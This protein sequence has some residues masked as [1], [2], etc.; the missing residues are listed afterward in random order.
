MAVY[1]CRRTAWWTAA[2]SS[3]SSNGIWPVDSVINLALSTSFA[4]KWRKRTD[5]YPQHSVFAMITARE[6]SKQEPEKSARTLGEDVYAMNELKG[7]CLRVGSKQ[8]GRIQGKTCF[9][10]KV[11]T[12]KVTIWVEQTEVQ[13]EQVAKSAPE[14]SFDQLSL[15]VRAAR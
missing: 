10:S 2:R 12:M 7:S 5:A 9:P 3:A 6:R 13:R 11:V 8:I 14:G 4:D 1:F 15:R